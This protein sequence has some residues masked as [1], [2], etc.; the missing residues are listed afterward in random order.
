MK[1]GGGGDGTGASFL[2]SPSAQRP[3]PRSG[4]SPPQHTHAII[5]GSTAGG[6][7]VS[8]R[9]RRRKRWGKRVD[10]NSTR[11][12]AFVPLLLSLSPG[13]RE[14]TS[15]ATPYTS[16]DSAFMA[17][18]TAAWAGAASEKGR[19]GEKKWGGV[20][21]V[22]GVPP[23]PAAAPRATLDPPSR[24][25]QCI[26]RT[27]AVHGRHAGHDGHRGRARGRGG[28]RGGG[29]GGG[30]GHTVC[31]LFRGWG[32]DETRATPVCRRG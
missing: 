28:R 4:R 7:R 14:Y 29:G 21:E 18:N 30:G 20:D 25:K 23:P 10:A 31:R 1:K 32:R 13:D 27:F 5:Y 26:T 2:R 3:W 12:R 15:G 6:G 17:S 16:C 22:S 19:E 9:R 24:I 11:P 8:R